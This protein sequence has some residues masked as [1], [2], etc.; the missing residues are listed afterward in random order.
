[1][2]DEPYD[3]IREEV[4]EPEGQTD[5]TLTQSWNYTRVWTIRL[6][7]YGPNSYDHL[8]AVRSAIMQEYFCDLL[9]EGMLFPVPDAPP[10][11][12]A[13]E[14][15][16]AQWWER[17]DMNFDMYEWVTETIERQF[18]DS[19][20]VSVIESQDNPPP[21]IP[22][23]PTDGTVEIIPGPTTEYVIDGGPF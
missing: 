15:F 10:P 21:P 17:A 1:M 5:I 20:G 23:P 2:R 22:P 19:V 18:V 16:N 4:N 9:A 12:R 6:C 7:A 11:I 8:R 13:P 3:K 14:L